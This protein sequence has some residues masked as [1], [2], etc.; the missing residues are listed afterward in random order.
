MSRATAAM[1]AALLLGAAGYT[2][3]QWTRPQTVTIT[4]SGAF[5][6]YPL[7]VEWTDEYARLHPEVKF[8]VSAGGAG[9]GMTDALNQLVDLGMV[10]RQVYPEE[11]ENGAFWVAVASDAVVVSVN[12][13]NPALGELLAS[14]LTAGKLASVYIHG[15]VTTWGQL[16]GDPEN[17]EPIRV[18]T[19]SDACGAAVTF[20]E[21]MGYAQ[22]DLL[23][24]GVY[25]DPGLAEAVRGD[26]LAIGY[27]NVNYA[28]DIT[29]GQ[30]VQGIV[31]VPLDVDGDGTINSGEAFYGDR[32]SM[33]GAI[34]DGLYPSPPTRELNLVTKDSFDGAVL[35]FVRWVL[36]EG[37]GMA[38][39]AGFVPL[40]PERRQ[41]ELAKLGG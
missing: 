30:P 3:Y 11:A 5:A 18:Y 1:I 34:A 22:E 20:A 23:G 35:D 17:T 38:E 4:A 39:E 40:S 26:P 8:E 25:G 16:V 6:L 41:Q 37:Q 27:N 28:Y 33:V 24:V 13:A 14:G 29:S 10:S 36:T 19:R 7:M 21:Y 15:N 31:V 12:S 2:F 9:K 32:A